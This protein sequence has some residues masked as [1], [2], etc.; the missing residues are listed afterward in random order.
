ME[1][2]PACNA[3][4]IGK[5]MCHRCKT[6]L[7]IL[8][9][10]EEKAEFHREKA[11]FAFVSNDFEQM[12]FHARRSCSLR[13]TPDAVRLLACAALVVNQFNLALFLWSSLRKSR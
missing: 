13:R 6:D 11:L 12:F 7:G 10:I 9:D 5:R 2:C 1:R 4:Y 8:I 3:K